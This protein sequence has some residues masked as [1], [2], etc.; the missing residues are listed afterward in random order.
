MSLRR[1]RWWHRDP[2]P[3]GRH[4][5]ALPVASV[6]GAA[7]TLVS[8][9]GLDPRVT[10]VVPPAPVVVAP[11]V[12]QGPTGSDPGEPGT[13]PRPAEPADLPTGPIPLPTAAVL[14]PPAP[15][16]PHDAIPLAAVGLVFSDGASVELEPDDPRVRTFRAA[17]AAL[18][19]PRT[20]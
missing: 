20:T 5:R 8:S 19:D 2:V 7:S 18:L 6:P 1:R 14:A 13:Q 4:A 3:A 10:G 16:G 15:D 17:A 9:A 11:E 12:V